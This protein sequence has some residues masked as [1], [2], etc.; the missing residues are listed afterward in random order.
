[1]LNLGIAYAL[2][3]PIGWNREHEERSA[4]IRT[5][6]IVAVASCGLAMVAT[7]IP[8]ATPESYSRVLQGLITGIGF[9]GGGAILR[10]K[11]GVHGTATAAFHD[12]EV[13][14]TSQEG[15]REG[16]T[17]VVLRGG[18][19]ILGCRRPSGRRWAGLKAR[20]RLKA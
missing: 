10:E 19:A 15:S 1:M 18:A 20:R 7:G 14:A 17:F 2:A 8:G 9:V 5:F 3:F 6:P 13:S 12:A 16:G 4:G 11:A